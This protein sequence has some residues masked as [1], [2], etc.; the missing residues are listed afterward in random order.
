MESYSPTLGKLTFYSFVD[1]I[2]K[3]ILIV[4]KLLIPI[5]EA[6]LKIDLYASYSYRLEESLTVVPQ[7]ILREAF[8]SIKT[9]K[10]QDKKLE[11]TKTF[12]VFL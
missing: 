2:F 9:L 8:Q 5:K 12:E 1:K 3:F 4:S 6:F 10:T 11:R 7:K